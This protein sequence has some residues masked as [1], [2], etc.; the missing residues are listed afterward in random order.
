MKKVL[1][2]G[3]YDLL[4]IGHVE[5]FRKARKCG[6]HLIVAVQDS[7]VILKYKPEAKMVK[8]KMAK[9]KIRAKVLVTLMKVQ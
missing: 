8:A 5:L 2:V 7:D 3:V 6:D 1:T 9:A 4:H